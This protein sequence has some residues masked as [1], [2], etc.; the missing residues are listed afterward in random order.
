MSISLRRVLLLCLGLIVSTGSSA[1]AQDQALE[2]ADA[3]RRLH[4]ELHALVVR[5]DRAHDLI[6]AELARRGDAVRA[7]APAAPVEDFSA[8]LLRRASAMAE[9]EGQSPTSD[10]SALGGRGTEVVRWGRAFQHEVLAV[11]ADPSAPDVRAALGSALDRYRSRSEVALPSVPKNMDILYAHP[12]ALA[13][14]SAY[15]D[16]DGFTWA[17]QWLRLAASEPLT[18]LPAGAAR[19]EGVDTVTARYFGKLTFGE[20]PQ[21]FPTEVPLAPAI[22]P[23]LIWLSPEAAIVWDNL[24]MLLEVVADVLAS[25]GTPDVPAAIDATL[26][27]FLDEEVAMTNQ[28]EWEIMALRH[29]IFFQGGYP[30]AVMTGN[31]RNA[32]GHAAHMSGGAVLRTLPGM[33][34]D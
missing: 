30:L 34:R 6:L 5:V 24:S 27:F 7:G 17:G 26:D 15:P 2:Q 14:R 11:L 13:F 12:Q 4:P 31:E 16:L 23:G 22:A 33:P 29:G 32:D 1:A 21:A 20:P 28:D 3:L 18:D 10:L 19:S 8:E 9:G 25:P